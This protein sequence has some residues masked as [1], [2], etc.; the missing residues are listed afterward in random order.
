MTVVDLIEGLP[1]E[2]F[3]EGV[4][5]LP[6]SHTLELALDLQ[7][8]NRICGFAS[9][10]VCA[11]LNEVG[12]TSRVEVNEVQN[13]FDLGTHALATTVEEGKKVYIDPSFG[14]FFSY[15]GLGADYIHQGGRG[16]FPTKKILHYTE[17]DYEQ[18]IDWV[19]KVAVDFRDNHLDPNHEYRRWMPWITPPLLD[20]SVDEIRSAYD[21]IWNPSRYAPPKYPTP[22]NELAIELARSMLNPA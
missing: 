15:V 11:Y 19:T 2:I 5:T 6:G 3:E 21:L 7:L 8:R 17:A 12:V 10:V 22:D 20:A 18:T 14:Q 4:R 16:S 1:I 9:R 13:K